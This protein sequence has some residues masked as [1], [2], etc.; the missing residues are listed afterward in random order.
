MGKIKS[1]YV[2]LIFYICV[3]FVALILYEVHHKSKRN[4]TSEVEVNT[5][6]HCII[7]LTPE[8]CF[9]STRL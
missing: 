3:C 7:A 6:V 5:G 4:V 8:Y 2:I 1:K 9:F